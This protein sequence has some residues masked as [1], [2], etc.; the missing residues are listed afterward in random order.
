MIDSKGKILVPLQ[1]KDPES[2]RR[3]LY[4]KNK[5]PNN[6][7]SKAIATVSK[8]EYNEKTQQWHYTYFYNFDTSQKKGR[9]QNRQGRSKKQ[10]ALNQKLRIRYITGDP[11]F[12]EV[13]GTVE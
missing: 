6:A 11:S 12:C 10:L 3:A 9:Y 1:H 7:W 2:A 5:A 8:V 13:L 4:L